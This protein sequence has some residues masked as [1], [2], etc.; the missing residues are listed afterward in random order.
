MNISN[1]CL[2]FRFNIFY[3]IFHKIQLLFQLFV[4]VFKC[5]VALTPSGIEIP[6]V[7]FVFQHFAP[8]FDFSFFSPQIRKVLIHFIHLGLHHVQFILQFPLSC[9]F[10]FL[11]PDELITVSLQHGILLLHFGVFKLQIFN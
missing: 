3:S 8:L 1:L 9:I 7:Q 5:L 4:F 2:D 11:I 10:V 6:L